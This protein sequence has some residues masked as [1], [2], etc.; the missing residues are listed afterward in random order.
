M[1]VELINAEGKV[2]TLGNGKPQLMHA[3]DALRCIKNGTHKAIYSEVTTMRDGQPIKRNVLT[4]IKEKTVEDLE[5]ELKA[6]KA[7]LKKDAEAIEK[8]SAELEAQA[9]AAKK[10]GSSVS[11]TKA[12]PRKKTTPKK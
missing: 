8:E 3:V 12:A 7:R 4:G 10:D 11:T 6:K 5:K 1:K 2:R 9:D